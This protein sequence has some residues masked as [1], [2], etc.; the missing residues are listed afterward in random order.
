MSSRVRWGVV[1]ALFGVCFPVMATGIRWLQVGPDGVLDAFRTDPLLWI[2]VTAPLFL[3]L[4]AA[5]GGH[6]HDGLRALSGA[7]EDKVKERTAALTTLAARLSLVLDSIGD[8][9]VTIRLDGRLDGGASAVGTGWFGP[10]ADGDAVAAWLCPGDEGFAV[11]LA[12]GLEQVRDDILPIEL[13]LDQL[14]KGFTR[15]ERHHAL[16]ARVI[17]TPTERRLLLVIRDITAAVAHEQEKAVRAEQHAVVARILKDPGGFRSF[18][19]ECEGLVDDIR[20]A[21]DD[22]V[23]RH[24]VHTLKGNAAVY[25]FARLATACQHVE[26]LFAER[27]HASATAD[28]V[29]ALETVLARSLQDVLPFVSDD[30]D[31]V[32]V[33]RQDVVSLVQAVTDLAPHDRIAGTLRGWSMEPLQP[34]F[35][36]LAS[37]AVRTAERLGKTVKV[38]I[39]DHGVRVDLVRH[40]SFFGTIVHVV[41]NA[42]A[43]GL[44][45]PAERERLGKASAGRITLSASDDGTTTTVVV[46]DDG[47]GIN[48]QAVGAQARRLGLPCDTDAERQAALFFDGMSTAAEVTELAGRGVGLG[49]VA[50]ACRDLGIAMTVQSEPGAGAT[51]TFRLRSEGRLVPLPALAPRSM[52]ERQVA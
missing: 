34:I 19:A 18:R 31:V 29:A 12:M 14:P 17:D 37:H 48:W 51:F 39:V 32:R 6:Q 38:D 21:T 33:P 25:G 3:G 1:G 35:D 8:A 10:V 46:A 13:T 5:L 7:L 41:R 49:A 42:V 20:A 16:E 27:G 22:A 43:H 47:G 2:I 40:A 50:A 24:R 45:A 44:E 9:L 23:V 26:D 30:D 4:F 36:R 15:G 28:V 11:A 52:V